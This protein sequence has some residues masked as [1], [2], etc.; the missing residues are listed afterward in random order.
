MSSLKIFHQNR[1][2][3]PE[4]VLNDK[5]AMSKTLAEVGVRYEQWQANAELGEQPTQEDVVAAYQQ[6]IQRL[7]DQD[8]KSVV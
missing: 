8:R 2:D 4:Q 1:P 5:A 7:L 6:D 3:H